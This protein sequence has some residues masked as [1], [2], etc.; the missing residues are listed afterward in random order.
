MPKWVEI[1]N[2]K[3]NGFAPA[4]T[5][6]RKRQHEGA[7]LAGVLGQ[8]ADL[9]VRQVDVRLLDLGRERDTSSRV[10]EMR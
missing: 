4:E 10:Y 7:L 9:V 8:Q 1:P 3:A 6:V 2:S 5:R